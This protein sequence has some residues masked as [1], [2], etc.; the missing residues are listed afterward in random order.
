MQGPITCARVTGIVLAT[1][2]AAGCGSGRKDG[3]VATRVDSLVAA[4]QRQSSAPGISVAVVRAGRDTLVLRGYG[5]A[6]AENGVP[7]TPETVY[8]IA[9]VT[10]QFTAAAVLQLAQDGRLSLDDPV[11]RYLPALPAELRPLLV[12]QLLNHTSGVPEHTVLLADEVSPDSVVA[13]AAR[14]PPAFTPG[15]Q[16]AYS[17]VGYLILG[18]LV[19]RVSGEP[20]A[21]YLETRVFRPAGLAATRH[22]GV[23]GLIPHRARGYELH[24]T[25]VNAPYNSPTPLFAAGALCST[26]GDLAAWNRA[27]ATGRVVAPGW[28]ARMTTP[29][30]AAREKGYGYGLIVARVDGRRIF[31]HSGQF[32]GFRSANLYL[33]DDSLSV[34]VLSNLASE[35]VEDLSLSIVR[36]ALAGAGPHPAARPAR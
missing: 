34:T 15:T 23:E 22:C 18:M 24:D 11:G 27:L 36:A 1:V 29:E 4:F 7:A 6:D 3:A 9:S 17:N 5:L 30:G 21:R 28:L 26:A 14:E 16:W 31:G 25:L 19:E 2:V 20:Y 13:L 35:S 8:A 10:K 33:P 12:R 32:A